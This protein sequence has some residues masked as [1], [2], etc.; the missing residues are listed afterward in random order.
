M[1][2]FCL[3]K[4]SMDRYLRKFKMIFTSYNCIFRIA[5]FVFFFFSFMFVSLNFTNIY[6]GDCYFWP[7]VSSVVSCSWS[8][9]SL[10]F[11]IS[12]MLICYWFYFPIKKIFWRQVYLMS[13]WINSWFCLS[14]RC[15]NQLI[16][17]LSFLLVNNCLY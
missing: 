1:H 12:S 6:P 8:L 4:D 11:L 5:F 3:Q 7:L 14:Q 2:L 13:S 10:L 17:L 15:P 9:F 16:I